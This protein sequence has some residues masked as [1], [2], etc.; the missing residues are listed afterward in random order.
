MANKTNVP[1]ATT[2]VAKASPMPTKKKSALVKP[3]PP[4]ENPAKPLRAKKPTARKTPTQAPA[5]PAPSSDGD[6]SFPIVGIGASAGGLEALG[7]LF[8]HIPTDTGMA[9]IVITH[10]HPGH[11]SLLPE[12]LGKIARIPVLV[13]ADGLKVKPNCIYVNPPGGSLAIFGG[14]LN[15]IDVKKEEPRH[16]PIDYFLRSLAADQRSK[17]ICIILSGRRIWKYSR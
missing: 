4:P 13:A 7:E 9:F 16:L 10:Q 1:P 3:G 11:I 17:A 5:A 2:E 8:T 14:M 12:L 6:S 15:R